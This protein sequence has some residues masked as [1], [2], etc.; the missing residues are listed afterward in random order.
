M[1]PDIITILGICGGI[2]SVIG[3]PLAIYLYKKQSVK[4]AKTDEKIL[5]KISENN[6]LQSAL[7]R[8]RSS[9]KDAGLSTEALV[10][11][12]GNPLTAV[13][14][15]KY[16]KERKNKKFVQL[17][18]R[19]DELGFKVV[20]GGVR[21][22]P[23]ILTSKYNLKTK[24]DIEKFLREK[25]LYDLPANQPYG[26]SFAVPIDLKQVFSEKK[27]L[28]EMAWCKTVFEVIEPDELFPPEYLLKQIRN[29][30]SIEELIRRGD[31]VFLAYSSCSESEIKKLDEKRD[32]IYAALM[33]LASVKQIGLKDYKKLQISDLANIL[34]P[35]VKQPEVVAKEIIDQATLWDDYLSGKV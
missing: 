12:Y 3:I 32:E 15:D 7:K 24:I 11:D 25:V 26:F 19:L 31:I 28:S 29:A 2:A 8:I 21:I 5:E 34:S 20:Q 35:Y 27:N 6:N 9:I 10:K 30:T 16:G 22:L 14:I 4:Q 18:K 1:S 23:P 33:V 13:L 17:K